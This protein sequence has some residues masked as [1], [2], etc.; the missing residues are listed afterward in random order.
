[1]QRLRVTNAEYEKAVFH[2][3]QELACSKLY[4]GQL[5]QVKRMMTREVQTTKEYSRCTSGFLFLKLY[6]RSPN[7]GTRQSNKVANQACERRTAFDTT[8]QIK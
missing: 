7:E 1:M 5:R 6:N 4:T 8:V 2:R 3:D